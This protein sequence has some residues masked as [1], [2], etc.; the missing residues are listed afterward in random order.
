MRKVCDGCIFFTVFFIVIVSSTSCINTKSLAYFGNLP[1]SA[2]I[3]LDTII[4]PQILIQVNDILQVSVGGENAQTV[5][6]INQY[7]GGEGSTAAL[8]SVV[9]VQGNI[10]L[11]EVGKIHVEGLTRDQARDAIADAYAVY[12]KGTLVSVKF[13]NFRFSVL[14]EVKGPGTFN[15]QSEKINLFEAMAQAG[16]MTQFAKRNTV[17]I[18]REENQKR[19]I[20]S[21]DFNDKSILNS[22]YYYLKRNDIIYVESTNLKSL[23]DNVARTATYIGAVT[24]IIALLLVIIK[25]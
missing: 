7:M 18:I 1:D 25:K 20:I 24:S 8:Q 13:G 4:P 15:V 22:P 10:E 19:E 21:V 14:G 3:A 5:Q 9:D 17:K 12:L 11:P 2:K 23:T 16:D 6:Y